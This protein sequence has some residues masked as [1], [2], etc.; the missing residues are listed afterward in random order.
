MSNEANISPSVIQNLRSGKQQDIKVSNLIKI[1]EVFGYKIVLE[2][3]DERLMLQETT[4]KNSK[5]YLSVVAAA[6]Q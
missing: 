1:A 2:K 6:Q 5:K 3:G 4:N